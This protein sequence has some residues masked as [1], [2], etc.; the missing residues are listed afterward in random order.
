MH[1]MRRIAVVAGTALA[2][3]TTG[4]VAL[5]FAQTAPPAEQCDTARSTYD[6]KLAQVQE[7]AR[8]IGLS[9][10]EITALQSTVEA[11]YDDGTISADEQ[12]T[13]LNDPAVVRVRGEISLG[14]LTLLRDLGTA[15]NTLLRC[16]D[17]PGADK[18]P[19][20]KPP[21]DKPPADKPDKPTGTKAPASPHATP[22]KATPATPGRPGSPAAPATPGNPRAQVRT[23]PQGAVQ[24]GD[25]SL[26]R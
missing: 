16:T 10:S 25:G 21:A 23:V 12:T 1:T 9:N 15:A 14:D 17:K 13:I 18:P 19:A 24:T 11:A 5:A 4:G 8:V 22:P 2:L 3:T 20:D 7:R 6:A 26:A